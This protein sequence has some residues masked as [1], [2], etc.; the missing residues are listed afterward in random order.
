MKAGWKTVKL[1]DIALVG[2]GNSAPQDDADFSTDG[3]CFVRTSDVGEVKFGTV[4][5][6]NDRLSSKGA[7][8]MRLWKAGTI[9]IPKSGASTF[10]NHR[11]ILGL[12]AHVSS[13]L[14]TI[15]AE[16]TRCDAR[17][18]LYYLSTVKAQDLIQDQ[19]YPSLKL[20]EIAGIEIPLP[21]LAEQKRI[22]ALL[23]E[24]FAGIDEAK[25]KAE[26][27]ITH[28]GSDLFETILESAMNGK[29]TEQ[30]RN[31]HPKGELASALLDKILQKRRSNWA[32]NGPYQTPLEP[33][34]ESLPASP[35]QWTYATIEQLLR[36][37]GAL[38]YGILKPGIPDPKGVPMV[39]VM[40][41]GNG[42]VN[43][44]D[45]MMV[46]KQLSDEYKRT[47]LEEDDIMLAVMAT[48]GRC[49]IVPP[50]LVGANVNRA[51]AVLKLS[52]LLHAQ[53]ILF[54]ILSPRIQN[55]FQMNKTGAAQA[56]INLGDLRGYAIPLPP[57]AEQRVII[58]KLKSLL[59][60]T[61]RLNDL[62]GQK[63]CAL[64]EL[65]QSLL[66]QAFAGE[67]TA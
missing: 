25:A 35:A 52:K 55:L 37:D 32:G 56:R 42:M 1:G 20:P 26:V 58:E 15:Q 34:T 57:I 6:S 11:V 51:L 39:R 7:K 49:A 65:K 3:P 18:L 48:I 33:D 21:Q 9:L 27:N 50:H 24:A 12:D 4:N 40:D 59:S 53:F 60:E 54:A 8:G 47:T 17:Y 36:D 44:T 43:D 67:L 46:S 19:S 29:L 38:S 2:A 63:M 13:H 64:I 61:R 28:A 14:A 16:P 23:D 5:S 45:L 10:V 31:E 62:Y 41:I 30:W 66:A 22:V